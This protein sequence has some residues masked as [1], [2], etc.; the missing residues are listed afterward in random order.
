MVREMRTWKSFGDKM[1]DWNGQEIKQIRIAP[2][3]VKRVKKAS[4]E[5]EEFVF[6]FLTYKM[7]F[8][9]LK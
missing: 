9:K 1:S 4:I 8:L 3:H 5:I 7:M 2:G 6:T